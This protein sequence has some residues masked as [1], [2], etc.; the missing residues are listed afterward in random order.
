M[1]YCFHPD[2]LDCNVFVSNQFDSRSQHASMS[3]IY[4]LLS[5]MFCCF[6]LSAGFAPISGMCSKYRSCTIN[7]D[8]GLGLAFTIAHE[9]GHKYVHSFFQVPYNFN[10]GNHML[11]NRQTCC[12]CLPVAIVIR[13]SL[14]CSSETLF[15]WQPYFESF[16]PLAYSQHKLE[17]NLSWK[18]TRLIT[19][20][21]ICY[22][23]WLKHFGQIK[24]TRAPPMCMVF[25]AKSS[26]ANSH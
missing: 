7:E 22:S 8:T 4:R 12:L 23:Q 6:F 15:L 16:C 9:S 5:P 25:G 1:H 13:G 14:C 18:T 26:L 19:C 20:C 21:G 24:W 10:L 17:H 3:F 2:L 11:C